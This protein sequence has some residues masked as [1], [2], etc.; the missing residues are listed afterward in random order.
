MPRNVFIAK[1]NGEIIG[2]RT[3]LSRTYTHCVA[4]RYSYEY[5]R[6]NLNRS[7]SDGET[8]DYLTECSQ[9]IVGSLRSSGTRIDGSTWEFRVEQH[10]VDKAL[11]ELAGR[12][13]EQ[14]IADR[15]AERLANLEKN[16]EAGFYDRW[17]VMT[18]CG[19]LD[20]AQKQVSAYCKAK[21]YA[22]VKLLE[23]ER[24]R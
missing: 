5:A 19:R 14:F 7:Y 6:Q 1:L 8:W 22:E 16:R 15:R 17:N 13:R 24:A 12:T 10:E 3:S 2:K 21:H 4:A 11:I 23:A 18:W 9:R 20:L